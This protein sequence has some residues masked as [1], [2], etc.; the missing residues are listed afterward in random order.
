MEDKERATQVT[1]R[2]QSEDDLPPLPSDIP[3]TS[4]PQPL[5]EHIIIFRC[6]NC[7]PQTVL[8]RPRTI[9]ITDKHTVVKQT[10]KD[11]MA[12]LIRPKEDEIRIGWE[13]VDAIYRFQ[14]IENPFPL[15]PNQSQMSSQSFGTLEQERCSN[16]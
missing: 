2:T 5:K 1:A 7:Y 10:L 15:A 4:T 11:L 6:P 8:Q 3:F 14:R 9:E 16:L 12:G 13:W